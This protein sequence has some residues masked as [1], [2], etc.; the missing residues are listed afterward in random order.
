MLTLCIF[1]NTRV[2]SFISSTFSRFFSLFG[3]FCNCSN[4]VLICVL[5]KPPQEYFSNLQRSTS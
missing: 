1:S 4:K 5:F 2:V 3:V